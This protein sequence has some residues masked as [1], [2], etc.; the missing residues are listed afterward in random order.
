[1]EHHLLPKPCTQVFK[2]PYVCEEEYDGGPFI[3]YPERKGKPWL[4]DSNSSSPEAF[5]MCFQKCL[6][7]ESR[8][9]ERCSVLTDYFL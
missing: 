3:T 8:D 1:M 4:V 9:E 6:A 7:L 2:V 5:G